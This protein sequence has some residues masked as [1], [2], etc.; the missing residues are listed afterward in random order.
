[1]PFYEEI[2]NKYLGYKTKK[3]INDVKK[4]E[5]IQKNPIFHLFE[6]LKILSENQFSSPF[7]TLLIGSV[8]I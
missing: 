6:N 3:I 2:L 7:P 1:M 8:E 5:K 4:W